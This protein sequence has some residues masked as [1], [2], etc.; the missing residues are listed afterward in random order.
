MLY[1]VAFPFN[2]LVPRF[3]V[4]TFLHLF[5]VVGWWSSSFLYDSVRLFFRNDR[6]E[7]TKATRQQLNHIKTK[8]IFTL[9]SLFS[10]IKHVIVKCRIEKAFFFGF[11]RH[12]YMWMCQTSTSTKKKANTQNV[13]KKDIHYT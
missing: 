13:F 8:R 12:R 1:H 2:V 10:I 3:F 9:F 5:I 11:D 7:L 4:E 6:I